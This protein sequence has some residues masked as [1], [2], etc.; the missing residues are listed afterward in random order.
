VLLV[1]IGAV[2][3]TGGATIG[4]VY[5]VMYAVVDGTRGPR[6]TMTGAVAVSTTVRAGV[7]MTGGVTDDTADV[8]TAVTSE[9]ATIGAAGAETVTGTATTAGAA[10]VEV[11]DDETAATITLATEVVVVVAVVVD[12]G[13]DA[14]TTRS[15]G[16][17][18][19]N[20]AG[21]SARGR[22]LM[23]ASRRLVVMGAGMDVGVGR[24]RTVTSFSN[25]MATAELLGSKLTWRQG[26]SGDFLP[27]LDA[28]SLA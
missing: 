3:T 4:S 1:S 5:A 28:G 16:G 20:A 7:A 18:A 13:P 11:A 17:G 21:I 8:D 27:F 2:A 23:S 6:L 14:D 12:V 19:P 15:S 9:T 25:G 10:V 26:T 24:C 22:G